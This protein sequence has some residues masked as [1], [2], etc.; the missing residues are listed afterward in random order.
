MVPYKDFEDDP[1]RAGN[2]LKPRVDPKWLRIR[3]MMIEMAMTMTMTMERFPLM[4]MT[5]PQRQLPLENLVGV[6]I[7]MFR[8]AGGFSGAPPC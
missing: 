1:S 4:A 7:G 8:A 6:N 2:I 3:C 5:M